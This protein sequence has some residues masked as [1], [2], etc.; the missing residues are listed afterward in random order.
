METFFIKALQLIIA[1]SI[2]VF[3]HELGHYLFARF[4]GIKVEKFYLFFNPWFSLYKWKPKKPKH[5]KYDKNGNEK[6]S[7]RDTVYGLGWLPLGGYVKIAGMIDESMDKEQMAQ[8]P[9]PWEFRTK[10]AYQRL[11]VMLAG[12]IFNFILAIA[13]YIGIAFYWGDR[14]VQYSQATEGM[15]YSEN[16]HDIGFEDGDILLTL[17]GKPIDVKSNGHIWEMIQD[18]A[19]IGV[20]RNNTEHKTITIPNGFLNELIDGNNSL[21]DY[22]FPSIVSEIVSNPAKEAGLMPNDRIVKVGSDTTAAYNEMQTS[23]LKYAGK[24]TTITVMRGDSIITLHV[25][26]TADGK[27][28][29][30]PLHWSQIYPTEIKEYNIFSAIPR[31]W[32]MGTQQLRMYVSSLKLVFTKEGAKSI[33]GFGAIGN[34]FPEKWSWYSFWQITA[35]LSVILAFMNIL[36]IPALDG[37]H[38]LFTL[39]EIITRKK[40]GEKFLEYAQIGGMA[41]LLLLLVYANGNDLYRLLF[42]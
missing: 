24:Q 35:F 18:G 32:E 33:G 5:R 40:P 14:V 15:N 6:A 41:F 22:R 29:F 30:K 11:L 2:L 27:L 42:Q 28:G 13:I 26:P 34:M 9:Q 21:F 20:L 37:G 25:T 36:P 19:K 39:Y 23:L 3:I 1:L 16:F 8:E 12:V 4:F 31:G 7:W 17:N 10:P 38:V